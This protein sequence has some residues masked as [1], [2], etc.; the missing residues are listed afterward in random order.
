MKSKILKEMEEDLHAAMK[1]E[2]GDRKNGRVSSDHTL[3]IKDVVRSVISALPSIGKKKDQ[4]TND[5]II[6]LLKLYIK[7]EKERQ[8]WLQGYTGE[9]F[10]RVAQTI[11]S[12]E[13]VLAQSYLPKVATSYEIRGWIKENIDFSAFKNK[14]QAM[15]L[16]VKQ[17][18]GNDG[19]ELREILN[20][21]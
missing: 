15:S 2:I 10:D 9:D 20:E 21:F 11:T 7:Q 14:M 4:V 8:L 16:L 12:P 17:F 1:V 13:I 6:K 3:A 19:L 5:A 18:P